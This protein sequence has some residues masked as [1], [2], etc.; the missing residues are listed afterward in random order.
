MKAYCRNGV[1]NSTQSYSECYTEVS[2]QF[3]T[4]ATLLSEKEMPVFTEETRAG[5]CVW[6]EE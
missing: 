4:S 6:R 5:L 3:H 1:Y 2:G